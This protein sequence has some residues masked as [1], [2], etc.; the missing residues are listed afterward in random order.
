[1]SE[2]MDYDIIMKD[3]QNKVTHITHNKTQNFSVNALPKINFEN[4]HYYFFIPIVIVSLLFLT[5]PSFVMEDVS[6]DGEIPIK[7][8]SVKKILYYTILIT[9]LAFI[10]IFA[11]IYNKK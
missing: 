8:V 10:L 5:T 11:F 4:K 6:I 1:M 9:F 3:L 2:N 7:K